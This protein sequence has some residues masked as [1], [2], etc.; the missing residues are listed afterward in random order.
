MF[1]H[2]KEKDG[3]SDNIINCFLRDSRGILWIGT[4]NGLNRFDGSNFFVYKKRKG[5]N[6]MLNEVVH[7]LCEDKSGNIWGSTNNGVF[8]FFTA[9]DSFMNY[10]VKSLGINKVFY[11]VLCD[12]QG[13]IWAIGQW[14]IFRF[15]KYENKLE[16]V[17]R[18]TNNP[19]SVDH[20]QI[21]KN[22]VQPD[23]TGEGL[24]I[25]TGSGIMYYD[26][27][28]NSVLNFSNQKNVSLFARRSVSALSIS[29]SGSL[30]FFDNNKKELISF[31]PSEKKI[32]KRIN[33]SQ[34][35]PSADGATIFE[36][37]NHRLWFSS[38]TYQLFTID[39]ANGNKV[40]PLQ[41][42]PDDNRTIAGQFFWDAFQDEDGTIWLGTVS[43]ISRCN[44]ERNIY[45]E[46]RLPEKIKELSGSAIQLAEE[47]PADKS[48]WII[49]ASSML[50][51]YYP[52]NDKYE[53]IDLSKAEPGRGGIMPGI[54]NAIRFFRDQII[55]TTY[56]G[57]WQL[58]K[59]GR[60]ISPYN[61]LPA[62]YENFKCSEIA[63]DGD[64]VLY[65]NNGKEL[66]YWNYLIDKSELIT[67]LPDTS[68]PSDKTIVSGLYVTAGHKVWVVAPGGS[69]AFKNNDH[70]LYRVK[71]IKDEVKEDGQ[72]VSINVDRKENVWIINRGVGLYRYDPSIQKINIWDETD[73]LPSNRMQKIKIDDE[74]RVWGMYYNKGSVFIPGTGRFYNFKIPIS[75][76]NLN[77]Y[78]HISS[79]S[80]GNIFCTINNEIVEFFPERI[81]AVPGKR[82]P[83]I[84]QISVNG[85]DFQVINNDRVLLQAF[86]NTIRIRFGTLTD[87]D[88]FPYDMEYMLEGAETNWTKATA[89]NEASYNN[90]AAGGYT[91]HVRAKS[92]SN[93]WQSE[94]AVF[95]FTI[96]T[97]F[98]KTIWF[99][100]LM[101]VLVLGVII[102]IYR[103]R[104]AQKEKLMQLENK[105]QILE[106]EKTLVQFENLKQHLNPHFLFNSLTSLSG[107]IEADQK[108]ATNFLNQMSKI[109][110]YILKNRE[111]ETVL[112]KEEI[113]FVNWYIHLQQTRFGK[114]LQVHF[115]V[116]DEMLD[117]K[118]APVT[119]QNMVEN[120]IK[121]NI[122]DVDSPLV[123][124]IE[125]DH[126]YIIIRNN[127]QKKRMVETSNQQGL[128][129]LHKLYR[130][131]TSRP[132]LIEETEKNY[133]IKIPL[134]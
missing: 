129:N 19:D 99:K 100:L 61:F 76:S 65:F 26:I 126:E 97:P 5:T 14:S 118:I 115:R 12:R 57:A 112:L 83:Q 22:G 48:F 28:K 45:V 67:Y 31:D 30:W 80:N 109:Y 25:A 21:R 111:S 8:C 103:F 60:K 17:F 52:G 122:V 16:E 4:Y 27:V 7:S 32:L 13:D 47:D 82:I 130:Y 121:H 133:Q 107:L 42:Q 95:H 119:L 50:I 101:G 51:H 105:A 6:S 78:S 53:V 104:M 9:T 77:Y 39:L 66:L 1:N 124:D 113:E 91:F 75:E 46:Y 94:D 128:A 55:I 43:G 69:I 3:L 120:A 84:S 72:F 79:R 40:G 123:I 93:T 2:L 134:I 15:K 35:A 98:Y 108:M 73:G 23:P 96:R 86:Q 54:C 11:K 58:S 116:E 71:I 85:G 10:S 56:T 38:W 87:R 125:T 89:N 44:P 74:G 68:L 59:G 18:L 62:G 24:W 132:I 131:L 63:F 70:K 92:K 90:L 36:D 34:E 41:H 64:S 117:R 49:T 106:K 110:R 88:I 37:R 33:I 29:A 81:V 114:G 127:L 102:F 20:F